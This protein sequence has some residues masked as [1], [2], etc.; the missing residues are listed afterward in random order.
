M[1]I[2]AKKSG[3][4]TYLQIV[5]NERD[6]QKV[7]QK[8][9]ATLGRLD[10]LRQS[11]QLDSL[12]RS[13]LRFSEKLLVLDAVEKGDCTRTSTRKIG[14]VLLM[15]KL[16]NDL[17]IGHIIGQL[18]KGRRFGFDIERV[19]FTAVLQRLF[20][21]GSDRFGR[22]DAAVRHCRDPGH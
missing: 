7:V 21:P 20:C 2:R 6:G 16:W 17:G 9:I 11:G 15:Q 18:T 5:E 8:V 1:F 10:L 22:G 12:L 4:R 3:E 14:A 19:V 13:G